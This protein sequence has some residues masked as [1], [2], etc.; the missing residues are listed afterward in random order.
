MSSLPQY[1]L[2]KTKVKSLPKHVTS[3]QEKTIKLYEW[4][5]LSIFLAMNLKTFPGFP[6]YKKKRK[7]PHQECLKSLNQQ[8]SWKVRNCCQEIAKRTKG[9]QPWTPGPSRKFSCC[10]HGAAISLKQVKSKNPY[11][12][13]GGPTKMAS[14]PPQRDQ[15]EKQELTSQILSPAHSREPDVRVQE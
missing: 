14:A 9:T 10:P 2:S 1:L 5:G 11:F 12:P 4:L 3:L 8:S 7:C 6:V 13:A 15:I